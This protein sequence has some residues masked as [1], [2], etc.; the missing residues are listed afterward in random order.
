VNRRENNPIKSYGKGTRGRRIVQ[1]LKKCG[2]EGEGFYEVYMMTDRKGMD[3][4]N[5]KERSVRK[6]NSTN[7][8]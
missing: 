1:S 3:N 8:T 2:Q 6:N 7:P 4:T 5:S